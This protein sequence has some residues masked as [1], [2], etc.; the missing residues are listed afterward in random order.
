MLDFDRFRFADSTGSGGTPAPASRL[1]LDFDRF[2]F[3][4]STGSGGSPAPA[5]SPSP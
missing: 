2:R 5:P 3:D 1:M 4:V